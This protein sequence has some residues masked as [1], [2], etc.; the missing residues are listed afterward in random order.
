MALFDVVL[1]EVKMLSSSNI[2]T[3]RYENRKHSTILHNQ[4]TIIKWKA[5]KRTLKT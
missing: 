4:N 5:P 1:I 2:V 3:N